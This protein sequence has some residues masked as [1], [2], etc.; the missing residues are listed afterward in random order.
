MDKLF[1]EV[2]NVAVGEEQID[3]EITNLSETGA[4]EKEKIEMVK[5]VEH[6]TKE[7]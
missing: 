2:D 5:Q 3:K 7:L 6:T 4:L 1:G